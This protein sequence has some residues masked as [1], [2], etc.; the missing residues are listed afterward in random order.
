[1]K[2]VVSV[3]IL[4]ILFSAVPLR[5]ASVRSGGLLV[6]LA[7]DRYR[8]GGRGV[9]ALDEYDSADIVGVDLW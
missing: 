6:R 2:K 8:Y 5:A 1:V 3:L 7:A 9:E 4:L